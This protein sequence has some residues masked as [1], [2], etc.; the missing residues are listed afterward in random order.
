MLKKDRHA[1]EVSSR[2]SHFLNVVVVDYVKDNYNFIV[3]QPLVV[4][5]L[6]VSIKLNL[7]LNLHSEIS[8]AFSRRDVCAS[9]KISLD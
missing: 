2:Y 4:K 1:M 6:D 9:K 7:Y 3:A 5:Q 8:H